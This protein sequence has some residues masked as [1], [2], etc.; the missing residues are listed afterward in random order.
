MERT[1]RPLWTEN[2]LAAFLN[3]SIHAVRRDRRLGLAPPHIRVA[4]AIRYAPEVVEA[5]LLRNTA[6]GARPR[7][8]G[9][10]RVIAATS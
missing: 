1:P 3:K 8:G 4:G 7:R 6:V 10:P 9:R 2:Q 5:Y